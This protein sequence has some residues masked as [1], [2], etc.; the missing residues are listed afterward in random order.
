MNQ[1]QQFQAH[2]DQP[3]QLV[4]HTAQVPVQ[5]SQQSCQSYG[6]LSLASMLSSGS[7]VANLNTQGSLLS[8]YGPTAIQTDDANHLYS[9][10]I[11]GC[12]SAATH[13]QSPEQQHQQ[14]AASCPPLSDALSSGLEQAQDIDLTTSFNYA[15]RAIE[16]DYRRH[17]SSQ[18]DRMRRE[19]TSIAIDGLRRLIPSLEKSSSKLEAVEAA[20]DY[21]K[22]LRHQ[23]S[24]NK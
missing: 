24:K 2:Q 18:R 3:E 23:I 20:V 9:S 1:H 14:L 6:Y 8:Q 17:R 22:F 21:I 19:R 4:Y 13:Q 5:P 7:S 11:Q 15:Y 16:Q 10:T 12:N